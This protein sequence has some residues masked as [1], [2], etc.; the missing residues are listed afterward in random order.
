MRDADFPFWG[1]DDVLDTIV[2]QADVIPGLA[3]LDLGTGTGALAVRLS[4]TPDLNLWGV[5]FSEEMLARARTR[6]PSAH[7]VQG[8]LLASCLPADLAR[9]YDRIV[10]G[11]VFHEFDMAVKL[12]LLQRLADDY[13]APEGRIVIGDIAFPTAM[14]RASAQRRWEAWWD[15]DEAY[16]AAD[17]VT[18]ALSAL[19]LDVTY[20]Q[21]SA[22]AGVFTLTR[23]HDEG[24]V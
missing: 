18:P 3:V 22:C 20:R 11:Y 15:L 10:S 9:R 16:W 14:L 2:R 4:G 23:R 24:S 8:D 7:F 17:E 1:Y 5:D 6:L 19:G 12:S 13:L 21:V